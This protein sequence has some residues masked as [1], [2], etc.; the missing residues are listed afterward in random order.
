MVDNT[1]EHAHARRAL[2]RHLDDAVQELINRNLTR[3]TE[4]RERTARHVKARQ[5]LHELHGG[6][7]HRNR[8]CALAYNQTLEQRH[9]L[10]EPALTQKKAHR[11]VSGTHRALDDLGALGDKDALLRLQHAAQLALRQSHVGVEP[12]IIQ[13]I[14]SQHLNGISHSS[15]PVPFFTAHLYQT[16]RR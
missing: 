13:G 16:R 14:D 4:R 7:E 9:H 6:H 5:L 2:T 11:L 10:I 12:L 1:L 8:T 15:Q 3:A